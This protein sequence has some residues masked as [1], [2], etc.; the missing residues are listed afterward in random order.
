MG[1]KNGKRKKSQ[2]VSYLKRV[3]GITGRDKTKRNKKG[4]GVPAW[5]NNTREKKT[6]EMVRKTLTEKRKTTK[7][8]RGTWSKNK[9]KKKEG[10]KKTVTRKSQVERSVKGGQLGEKPNPVANG[11]GTVIQRP[12][13][14]GASQR[15]ERKK[16]KCDVVN[17]HKEGGG[18]KKIIWSDKDLSGGRKA[19]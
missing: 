6:K 18:E 2:T 15:T 1:K 3:K 13:W 9:T 5:N 19:S 16:K 12:W 4:L 10:P 17:Q 7:R 14:T 11:S 8:G